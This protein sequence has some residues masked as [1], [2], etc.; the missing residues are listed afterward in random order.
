MLILNKNIN[1][2]I[3]KKDLLLSWLWICFKLVINLKNILYFS[4]VFYGVVDYLWMYK[5]NTKD[6]IYNLKIWKIY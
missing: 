2:A 1:S 6:K 3:N 4:Y 5:Q